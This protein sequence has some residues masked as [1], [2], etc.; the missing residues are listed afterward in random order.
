MKLAA[1]LCLAIASACAL[2]WGFFV[3]HGVASSL[4]PLQLRHPLRALRALFGNLRW[5]LGYLVGIGGWGL[6]IA[7][8]A[9]A[10]LSIVQAASGGG[11][12][13]LAFLVYRAR[14]K[15]LPFRDASGVVAAMIGLVLLGASLIHNPS[16][17]R[18][19]A[20]SGVYVWIA[21]SLGFVGVLVARGARAGA[22]LGAAAGILYAT[23]DIATKAAFSTSYG[24]EFVVV[25]LICHGLGF[26]ALQRGFQV[27]GALQTAGISTMLTNSLPILA[28]IVVFREGLPGVLGV[29]RAASFVL[30]LGAAVVLARA[31][32]ESEPSP[33]V[34]I[35]VHR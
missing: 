8:L 31:P 10:P 9:L 35:A 32:G 18:S 4:P 24:V 23:G 20:A 12:G 34:Q 15:R 25:L 19:V 2:N 21:V 11:I 33:Q 17:P 1:G 13:V 26:V 6:Y 28:G 3:Q 16:S 7:A 27:G 22:A 14:R 5:L 30:V 29:V